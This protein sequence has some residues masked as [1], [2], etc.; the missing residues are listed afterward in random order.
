MG[1]VVSFVTP[2]RFERIGPPRGRIP[3]GRIDLSARFRDFSSRWPVSGEFLGRTGRSQEQLQNGCRMDF[4]VVTTG[5]D[6]KRLACHTSREIVR[7]FSG[8]WRGSNAGAGRTL[9][10]RRTMPQC[11]A[12]R[13]D[14]PRGC[15][16]AD[17]R[18]LTAS[19]SR[20]R[21]SAAIE[22]GTDEGD[23]RTYGRRG[24]SVGSP[25]PRGSTSLGQM[26]PLARR[27]EAP[28]LG[29]GWP[30]SAKVR[31]PAGRE[32][33]HSDPPRHVRRF[34]RTPRMVSLRRGEV[35]AVETHD[36]VP[37]AD[38]VAHELFLSVVG[39]RELRDRPQFRTRSKDEIERHDRPHQR[40]RLDDPGPCRPP[41]SRLLAGEVGGHGGVVGRLFHHAVGTGADAGGR[42]G[43]SGAPP[44]RR[45]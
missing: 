21:R 5:D 23:H 35:E 3:G 27:D 24:R 14:A 31:P 7:F 30:R 9:E 25:R 15:P 13:L 29:S 43:G 20:P 1:T 22:L 34:F 8:T 17:N 10:P 11:C 2:S 12:A 28:P 33:T 6:S 45:C 19:R 40:A 32:P 36:L 38:K 4:A 26:R 39:R 42:P 37:C 18:A 44:W 16:L 41:R